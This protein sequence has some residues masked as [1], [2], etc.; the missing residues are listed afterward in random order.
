LSIPIPF[1]SDSC[2]FRFLPIPRE[3]E[4]EEERRRTYQDEGGYGFVHPFVLLQEMADDHAQAEQSDH[5]SDGDDQGVIR[6]AKKARKEPTRERGSKPIGNKSRRRGHHR[7]SL[8]FS[9]FLSSFFFDLCSSWIQSDSSLCDVYRCTETLGWK[10]MEEEEEQSSIAMWREQSMESNV[11]GS[12]ILLRFSS[13][14]SSEILL[15]F[16]SDLSSE[17]H[18]GFSSDFSSEILL[19]FSSV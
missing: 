19:R 1:D 16:N 8:P 18:L 3:E 2:R 7:L 11:V 14:L 12:E 17:I 15:R 4:K 9:L 10:E 6:V 5:E 13:D